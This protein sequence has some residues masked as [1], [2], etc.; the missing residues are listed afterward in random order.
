VQSAERK[1]SRVPRSTIALLFVSI[2]LPLGL[3]GLAA[4]ENRRDV[5]RAAELRVE[6]TTRILHEHALKVFE[7]H[8]LMIDQINERLLTLNWSNAKDVE[9]LHQQLAH[10]QALLPQIAA[11]IITDPDG[12]LRADSL[13]YPVDPTINFADRDYFKVLK[14]NDQPLP[15]I[16]RATIG[17]QT[18]DPVF[19]MA[20]RAKGPIDNRFYGVVSVSI[21]QGYFSDFYRGTEREYAHLVIL[22]RE[23]GSVLASEPAVPM[24][25][26]P[27]NAMFRLALA[28]RSNGF[29][30]HPAMVDGTRRIFGYEKVG[31]YPVV[32]GFGVSWQSAMLPW[33]RNMWGY[34]LVAGLSSLAL[35][36]VSGFA[37]RRIALE[38]RATV[39]W[40]RSAALLEAEM[41][42]RVKIENQ[43]RQSQKMEA[44][45]R[46]TGGIAHDFNN[47]LT[48]VIGSLDLL[49][50]RMKDADPRQRGL[51]KNAIDGAT[52]AA[53]LTARL[54]A[55]S[56]QHPLEPKPLDV[57]ALITDMSSLLQRTLGETVDIDC[58][59][60]PRL[61]RTF[62]DPNQLE[63][64]ILNLCVNAVDAMPKGGTVTLTTA[65]T[66]LERADL[67]H[68][69]LTMPEIAPGPYVTIAVSDTGTGMAPD[70]L[71]RA[72]EPFFTTKP[73]GKGTGLGLSQV[74]GFA[75][76][77]GG[78]VTISSKVGVGTTIVIRLPKLTMAQAPL[79]AE[80][81]ATSADPA[82]MGRPG[83]ATILVVEDE[84][85]V[86]SFSS[87][88][89]RDA[90]Y[91]VLEAGTGPD[92]LKYIL[93]T[94]DI[95]LLFTDV[96]LKG[97]MNGRELADAATTLRPGLPVLF[98]TGYT[99][100]AIVH[101]GRLDE[102][103]N[104]IGKPFT[105][106]ALTSKI[107]ELLDLNL[108]DQRRNALG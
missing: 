7:T 6:R 14:A 89:L 28:S 104:F 96:V 66:R 78:D 34:G 37:I 97:P 19:N 98:T 36:A 58:R 77:S 50:R 12:N 15:Y 68:S 8:Q 33:W 102:G 75:R 88:A 27:S 52:R 79:E 13:H 38:G 100:D 93:E 26:L 3:F 87:A 4:H 29:Q 5:E 10:L 99:K 16:S 51:V 23:D 41:A 17:R 92:G 84:E 2:L 11:I 49:S 80:A 95:A 67:P 73:V 65:N 86:R 47:L 108:P 82:S 85:L 105:M 32:I 22:A 64:A 69:D 35:L 90:G 81:P 101:D 45:G 62:A 44:V 39:R 20:A 25:V 59:L 1:S 61:D 21:N 55:F 24:R 40:R 48:V 53:S 31:A 30:L 42:Q 107:E 83:S 103:L 76:Q 60:E 18:G 63:N 74:Y 91:K 56:R 70:V 94:P 46:L 57:N 71:A 43:L 72:F 54:L 9:S 106:A